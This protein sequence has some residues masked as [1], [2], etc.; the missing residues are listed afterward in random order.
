V[1]D[2]GPGRTRTCNQTVMS[3][4]IVIG[5]DDFAAFSSQIE[6]IRCVL[7][8]SFLVRNW[9]GTRMPVEGTKGL[10]NN[11]I[12]SSNPLRSASKSLILQ[13]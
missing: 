12:V 1:Q 6:R 11:H 9:R 5:P 4:K 7:V 8:R 13:R 10:F 2:G 3:G